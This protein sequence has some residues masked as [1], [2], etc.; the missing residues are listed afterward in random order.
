MDAVSCPSGVSRGSAAGWGD[1]RSVHYYDRFCATHDRYMEANAA[2]IAHSFL[3]SAGRILDF[4]AGLGHTARS[5]LDVLGDAARIVCF[6]PSGAMR[7]E[8]ERR[9]ADSRVT[10]VATLPE[11]I[12]AFDRV[13]CGA[14]IWQA[15]PLGETF[16]RLSAL[17]EPGGALSFNIPAV[18]LGQPDPPGGGRDPLLLEIP[19]RLSRGRGPLLA[20]PAPAPLPP[21]PPELLAPDD[22]E[23]LLVAASFRPS[24][25]T[26]E[27]RLTLGAYRDWLKIP[28]TTDWL[29][30]GLDPDA[31]AAQIDEAHA[32]CD[33][34]SWRQERWLGWTAWKCAAR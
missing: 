29:L 19:S 17:I 28:A 34:A 18:Y 23:A 5:A 11:E 10:W 25:W 12:E 31:R 26:F 30:A 8:G 14:S 3:A 32:A 22:L 27:T 7:E 20:P 4:G 13:L 6:E 16:R 21:A 24:R 9:L 2:L 33:P 15:P 1:P